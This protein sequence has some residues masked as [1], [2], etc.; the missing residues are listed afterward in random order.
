MCIPVRCYTVHVICKDGTMIRCR[1]FRATDSGVLFF[2]ETSGENPDDDEEEDRAA[3][4]FIP[5]TELRFVLPDEMVQQNTMDQRTG[6]PQQGQGEQ[7]PAGGQQQG[8]LTRQ[9]QM[10]QSSDV[11]RR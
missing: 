10:Q 7:V 4:G 8:G 6:H 3:D 9:Q 1:D 5:V 11:S 2:Q